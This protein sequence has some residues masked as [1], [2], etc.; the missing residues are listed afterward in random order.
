[1]PAVLVALILALFQA[2]PPGKHLTAF[3]SALA[4]AASPGS[5]I[6]LFVDVAPKPGIHVYAPGARDYLPIA[7][8]V[9]STRGVTAGKLKIGRASCRERGYGCEASGR[10]WREVLACGR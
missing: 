5:K 8:K 2:V 7:L 10:V 4:D 6:S 1:M 9:E 3:A